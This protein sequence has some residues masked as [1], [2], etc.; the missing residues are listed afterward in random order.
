MRNSTI[1]HSPDKELELEVLRSQG[2][3][4]QGRNSSSALNQ[5]NATEICVLPESILLQ[6]ICQSL[7]SIS[8]YLDT[9]YSQPSYPSISLGKSE[10]LS[11]GQSSDSVGSYIKF[12]HQ[13]EKFPP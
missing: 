4:G 5:M 12:Y 7:D 11:V 3:E 10:D 9:K 1:M 2:C 6:I 13:T 8:K